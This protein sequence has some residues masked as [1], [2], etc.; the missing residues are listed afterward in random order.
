M[1]GVTLCIKLIRCKKNTTVMVTRFLKHGIV[2]ESIKR[3]GYLYY[4][5]VKCV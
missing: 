1:R 5:E 4:F 2:T 3:Q